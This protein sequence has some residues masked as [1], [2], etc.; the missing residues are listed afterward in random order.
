M[1]E[2]SGQMDLMNKVGVIMTIGG[3]FLTVVGIVV[4]I[5]A[6]ALEELW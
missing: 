3:I 6:M 2:R 1:T 4:Q 5:L